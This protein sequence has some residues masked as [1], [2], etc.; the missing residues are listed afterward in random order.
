MTHARF[1]R[2]TLL[3]AAGALAATPALGQA[4][5]FAGQTLNGAAFQSTF[6][7]YLK[8]F[9]PEFEEATGA[10]VNFNT[11]AFPVYN[12]R[13]DLEL[14]TRG[15]ALDVVN[16]TFI[17]SGRWIGAGW[18]TNL[19][20]FVN[21]RNKTDPA[22]DAADFVSGAQSAMSDA[23]GNVFGFAWEAGAMLMAASRYDLLEKNGRSMPTTFDELLATCDA[24][25]G[26]ENVTAFVADRLHHWN[27]IPY[28]MGLGGQVFKDPPGN[29]TPRLATPEAIRA[30]QWYGDLL[31]KFAP[32]GGLSF[33]DDQAMRAQMSGRSNIRTQAITWLVPLAKHEES[34]VKSTV[35]YALM[36][37]GP[38]GNFPGSNSHGLGIP[39]GSRR[40]ELAWEFI[41][42]ALSKQM[43][44]RIVE[45]RGY[46]SVCRRSVITGDAFRSALT[47]NGQDVASLY[48]QVLELGGRSGYM[49]YRTVPVFPQV[50]DTI[51]RGIERIATRQQPADAA[52]RQAQ[53]DA[54]QVLGRAGVQVD[55]D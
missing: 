33:S 2:R 19:S 23:R 14:S 7:E 22:W 6:F 26:K 12:Q 17:Y 29:L 9:F 15:S 39:V 11:Q 34:T 43:L 18:L 25:H 31:Q 47:L 44:N 24:I 13:T 5:P 3:G 10:R 36:P 49:K 53:Q 38:A 37:A 1:D 50:G 8:A 55:A 30:A 46:P 42:W 52:M 21:D 41:K 20:E 45:T 51:N 16:V 35:R 40:K 54:V 4:K 27:W 28:L 48:L 32:P